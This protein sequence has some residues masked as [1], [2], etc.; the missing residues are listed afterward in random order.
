M[1][2]GNTS[3]FIDESLKIVVKGIHVVDVIGTK[4]VPSAFQLN[5]LIA[6]L[7][8]NLL[9]AFSSQY[10]RLDPFPPSQNIRAQGQKMKLSPDC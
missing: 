5:S 8:R 9:Y 6:L 1:P 2:S 4:P 7:R 3:K 10:K